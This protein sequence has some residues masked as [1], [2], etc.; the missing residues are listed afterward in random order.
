MLRNFSSLLYASLFTL[1]AALAW[2][3]SPPVDFAELLRTPAGIQKSLERCDGHP[4]FET[5]LANWLETA[6]PRS[7]AERAA[8]RTTSLRLLEDT[9]DRQLVL[10]LIDGL[11]RHAV[12]DLRR[13]P[14]I[15]PA[16]LARA[17]YAD[18]RKAAR[19]QKSKTASIAVVAHW[20]A[21]DGSAA[22]GR[23]AGFI[24]VFLEPPAQH[25]RREIAGRAAAAGV[26]RGKQVA[27][28]RPGMPD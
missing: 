2:Q 3:K 21:E 17:L 14:A 8:I 15:V 20:L 27:E 4:E 25:R 22:A 23:P 1:T 16:E 6:Q 13:D 28:K 19:N 7:E 18:I 5:A 11:L 10:G 12:E 24:Q 9:A 26:A